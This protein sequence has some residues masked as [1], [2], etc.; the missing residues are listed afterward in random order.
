[1]K[2]I[3]LAMIFSER[4]QARLVSAKEKEQLP[5]LVTEWEEFA[6]DA[7]KIIHAFADSTKER[8]QRS[9]LQN[10]RQERGD[11]LMVISKSQT[12]RPL[13]EE[14]NTATSEATEV[15]PTIVSDT[16][17]HFISSE[18]KDMQRKKRNA[19]VI[20]KRE[21][22]DR[23]MKVEEIQNPSFDIATRNHKKQ[24]TEQEQD[25]A[26]LLLSLSHSFRS[27]HFPKS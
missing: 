17:E 22:R 21:H 3:I 9:E 11:P 2:K 14:L 23:E 26:Q 6:R 24:R 25:A 7:I 1:M 8:N 15:V 5:L 10:L 18:E 20:S 19:R 27:V 13:V 4:E 16:E 12:R